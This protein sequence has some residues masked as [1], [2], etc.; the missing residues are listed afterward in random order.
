[1][2]DSRESIHTSRT[3]DKDHESSKKKS[4]GFF[5][6]LLAQYNYYLRTRPVLTKSI[7]SAITSGLGQL[8]SQKSRISQGKGVDVRA[9]A[10]FSTFGFAV[11]GPLVH[12]FYQFLEEYL[13]KGTSH[14]QA[15]KLALDRLVFSPIFYVLFFYIIS[16]LE[17][18]SCSAAVKK[19]HDNFWIAFKMSLRVWVIAQYVNFNYVPVEYRVLFA[20]AIALGWNA[21]M[22]S[23]NAEK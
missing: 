13:P 14:A 11:T 22:A 18:K 19:V 8:L 17:G 4:K 5:S 7:T 12:Y 3:S 16:L 20:N 2:A 6:Q 1:M 9:V 23:K 21:F 15:K 10:A